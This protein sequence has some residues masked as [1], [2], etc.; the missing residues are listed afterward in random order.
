MTSEQ[1]K[2]LLLLKA[3][4]FQYH[5]F[6]TEELAILKSTAKRIDGV[7]E[8]DWALQF[9]QEDEFNTMPRVREFFSDNDDQLNAELKMDFLSQVWDDNNIKG[10]ITELEATGMLKI[11]TDWGLQSELMNMVRS[12]SIN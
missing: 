5:G 8:M 4:I 3:V 12:K 6:D 7:E 1:K 9:L 2:I 11:A 10:Y